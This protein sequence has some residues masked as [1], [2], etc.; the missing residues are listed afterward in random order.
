MALPKPGPHQ[1]GLL[2]VT[3]WQSAELSQRLASQA[4]GLVKVCNKAAGPGGRQLNIKEFGLCLDLGP[5]C[6][7]GGGHRFHMSSLA[8][9]SEAAALPAPSPEDAR[10]TSTLC[11]LAAAIW[12]LTTCPRGS[13]FPAQAKR[14]PPETHVGPG[15][16]WSVAH[17]PVR[18]AGHQTLLCAPLPGPRMCLP[19]A[20]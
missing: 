16:C 11:P 8:P 14:L 4:L 13:R 12:A 9:H 1:P 20:R 19:S 17:R 7:L 5:D 10:P 18:N 15:G 6:V 2:W 3:F